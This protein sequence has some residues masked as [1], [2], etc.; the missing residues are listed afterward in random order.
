MHKNGKQSNKKFLYRVIFNCSLVMVVSAY[1]VFMMYCIIKPVK[2]RNKE[3]NNRFLGRKF[4]H[5]L[6]MNDAS[7]KLGMYHKR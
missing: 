1:P 5:C 6:K 3:I 4:L 2:Y 7:I